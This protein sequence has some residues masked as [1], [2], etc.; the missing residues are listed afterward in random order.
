MIE[1]K[2]VSRGDKKR[3]KFQSFI[4][5]F[6]RIWCFWI[7]IVS[8]YEVM[9]IRDNDARIIYAIIMLSIL[10]VLEWIIVYKFKNSKNIVILLIIIFIG[11][12]YINL[13]N[14]IKPLNLVKITEDELDSIT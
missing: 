11:I 7:I 12:V 6:F 5:T 10:A 4:T 1:K 8:L 2:R 14:F 13:E 3:E 9:K